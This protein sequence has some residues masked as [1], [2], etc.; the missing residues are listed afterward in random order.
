MRRGQA[1]LEYVLSLA[2]LLVVVAV[3]WTLVSA[4]EKQSHRCM[5]LVVSEYP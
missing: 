1:A 3:M 2:G 4:S 5:N